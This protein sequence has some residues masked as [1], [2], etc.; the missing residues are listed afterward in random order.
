MKLQNLAVIFIVIILPIAL[1]LSVYTSNLIDVT[2]KQS[3][4]NALLLNSTYDAVRA[5]QINTL[6]NSYDS[7]NNSK[8][9]DINA[10]INSF[11]NSMAIGLSSSGLT[12]HELNDYIPALLYTLYDGYYVYGI[13]DNVVNTQ[14]EISYSTAQNPNKIQYGLKPYVYYSCEYADRDY[15]LV[16]NYTLDNYITVTGTYKNSNGE[17]IYISQSG[18]YI[19][20]KNV[21]VADGTEVPFNEKKVTLTKNQVTIEPEKLGEY[22]ITYDTKQISQGGNLITEYNLVSD[23]NKFPK[24]YNYIIYNNVKYY[25]DT[26]HIGANVERDSLSNNMSFNMTYDGYP[27]FFLEGDKRVYISKNLFDELKSFLGVSADADMYSAD[28]C[29]RDVNAFY[30]YSKSV[31]FSQAVEYPLG[32]IDLGQAEELDENGNTV[33][34]IASNIPYNENNQLHSKNVIKTETYHT[35]YTTTNGVKSHVKGNYDTPKV[36]ELTEE[37]NPELESSS[38]NR[39]RIDVIISSIE[40]SLFTTIANFNDY[41]GGTYN[42][43]MPVI[44]EDEWDRICNNIT[45]ASF[46]QGMPIGNFKYYSSYAIVANTKVNDFISKESIYVQDAQVKNNDFGE[47][48][49]PRCEKYNSEIRK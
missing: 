31:R 21:K 27:I 37:N 10:S 8:V 11:F 1:I 39:H 45:I 7:V 22:L 26:E 4:Y 14:G 13:Y 35:D 46:M 6:N 23:A 3:E 44:T 40:S 2:N 25:L 12:K 15:D 24:Y 28:K 30:Y 18:Y 41:K 49:N 42:Y 36:F 20:Y 43:A 17:N 33:K 16:I 32:L 19:N 34:V 48:H 9:R 5:Y 47:Y 38:F 29:F